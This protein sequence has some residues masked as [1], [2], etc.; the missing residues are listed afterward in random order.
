MREVASAAIVA[1]T[2]TIAGAIGHA[3]VDHFAAELAASKASRE[4]WQH[5]MRE[6]RA[7]RVLK[8][9]P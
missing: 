6:T 2:T 9:P 7:E 8:D 1:F 3:V 4:R 5:L